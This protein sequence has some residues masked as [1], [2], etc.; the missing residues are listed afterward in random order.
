VDPLTRLEYLGPHVAYAPFLVDQQ[1]TRRLDAL[2]LLRKVS[3]GRY[4]TLAAEMVRASD[5]VTAFTV[6]RQDHAAQPTDRSASALYRIAKNRWARWTD[7]WYD[8]FLE[9]TRQ[10]T[11]LQL[12][13]RILSPHL[14]LLIGL[15]LTQKTS[16]DV[17]RQVDLYARSASPVHTLI[18]WIHELCHEGVF[19]FPLDRLTDDIIAAMIQLKSVDPLHIVTF[20]TQGGRASQTPEVI[21]HRVSAI[22]STP[23]L[24]PLFR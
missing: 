15:L 8:V 21:R 13:G 19:S 16:A 2:A 24:L 18:G 5:A 23:I 1:R 20:V 11:G 12:R 7:L 9:E 14:R 22:G 17:V 10:K 6:L 3:P 4:A